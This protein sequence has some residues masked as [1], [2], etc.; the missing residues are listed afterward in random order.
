M[1]EKNIWFCQYTTILHRFKMKIRAIHTVVCAIMVNLAAMTLVAAQTGKMANDTVRLNA[2]CNRALD[3]VESNRDKSIYYGVRALEIARKLDQKFYEASILCDLGYSQLSN[4]D[5]SQALN[6]LL[7]AN[8]LVE[9]KDI[10]QNV[11][12]TPYFKLFFK[13]GKPEENRIRLYVYIKSNLGLLYGKTRNPHKQIEVLN[14]ALRIVKT[15]TGDPKQLYSLTTNLVDAYL[16][17]NNP[18][19]ALLYQKEVLDIDKKIDS[20]VYEGAAQSGYASIFLRKHKMD[21]ARKYYLESRKILE[22]TGENVTFL[23]ATYYGLSQVYKALGK[24]DSSL[25]FANATIKAYQALGASVPEMAD[26]YDALSSSFN[27]NGRYDSAFFYTH[28]AKQLSD[29]LH[30]KEIENLAR[31]QNL[32]FEELLRLKE[33]ETTMKSLQSRRE[34]MALVAG[35][36]VVLAIALLLYRNNRQRKKANRELEQTLVHLRSTQSQLVQAEKMASLGE[37][38]AGIAHEIQ[39]PLNFVNNFSE[40]SVELLDELKSEKSKP[41]SERDET[42]EDELLADIS[43]NLVKI[44]HHGKRAGAIVKGMLQHSRTSSGQKEQ[45]DLNALCDEYLRLCYHGL[46]AKDKSFNAS[47]KTD[48]DSTIPTINLVSQDI[49]RAVLNLLT[50]A[51]YA[52]NEKRKTGT[53]GFTPTVTIATKK[54]EGK[55]EIRI[56]DNGNGIPGK[57]LD[58]IFQPFFTTKPNGEGT[59]LGLSLS[60]DIVVK[61]HGGEMKVDTEEGEGTTFVITLPVV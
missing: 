6:N 34:M 36:V 14:E 49:G 46:R 37:L 29:S 20:Q 41:K 25:F 7:L 11:V 9:D 48:F 12:I 19:S 60:Y 30:E 5:Y 57:V 53:V 45:T 16:E 17:I 50:N 8:K 22:K 33:A 58:K 35:L 24:A 38:T 43:V 27:D 21:S 44:Q 2:Y 61:G 32:G 51:F 26:A 13:E 10:G 40:V 52:V 42:L 3:Y 47:I 23:A 15:G 56:S 39:N 1:P 31:F 54:L 55:V 59:G 18:D 28:L 4:G